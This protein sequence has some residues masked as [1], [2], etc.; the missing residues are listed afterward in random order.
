MAKKKD[1]PPAKPEKK[2]GDLR[3]LRRAE[4]LERQLLRWQ[5]KWPLKPNAREWLKFA[6]AVIG[7]AEL[8]A[9]DALREMSGSQEM[10]QR[11]VHTALRTGEEDAS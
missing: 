2:S 4:A 3:G 6:R 11:S 7:S 8:L 5:E 9:A 10:R 1:I